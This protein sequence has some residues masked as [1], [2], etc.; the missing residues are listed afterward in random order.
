VSTLPLSDVRVIEMGQLLAGPFCG[1]LLGDFGAEVIKVEAPDEG[2]AMRGWGRIKPQGLSLHWPII[3]RNKK[4]IT[5]N[6]RSAKGQDLARKLVA[7]ADVL[8]ENFRS[9]TLE[10]WGL[11]PEELWNINPGLVITRVTGYGQTGPYAARAG[12]GVVGEAMGGFRYVTGDPA[13]PPARV[14]V[15]I[16]DE[17]AGTFAA[18][19][20]LVALHHRQNT[21]RGQVVDASL[22]ESVFAMM[23]ALVPDWALGGHQ[24]ERTGSILP[25]IAPT[26]IYPTLD[27]SVL[28]AGNRDTIFQRL[29]EVMGQPKLAADPRFATHDARGANSEELDRIISAW[30][31]THESG[32]LL[33]ILHEAGVPAGLIYRAKD[34]LEDPHFMARE[35][36][37][38]LKH[39]VLGDFPMQGVF[40]KLSETP[41]SVRTLGPK[42]GEH[43]ADVYRDLLGLSDDE[44]AALRTDAII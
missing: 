24:R 29:T 5:L 2:D 41:G 20:T 23:E 39:D 44:V 25:G 10:R 17:L 28:I 11:G 30:S 16:G 14:G 15:S 4:S 26:N 13:T 6:L 31:S 7:Q 43:N 21:G 33:D 19:G 3:G 42:L 22:Y 35:S 36:I 12:F 32:P 40:P 38:R 27:G 1:Q 8:V 34:M 9:G 18:L 37:I